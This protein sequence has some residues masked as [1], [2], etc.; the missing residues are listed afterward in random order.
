MEGDVNEDVK[1]LFDVASIG[2]VFSTFVG[3]LPSIA[4]ALTVIWLAIRI[5]E[6]KT[7]RWWLKRWRK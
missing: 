2:V 5:W 6:S 3:W 7:M 4:S 1:N